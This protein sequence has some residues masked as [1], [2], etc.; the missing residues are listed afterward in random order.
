MSHWPTGMQQW[1]R[2]GIG[3]D[4]HGDSA[5]I[6]ASL[7]PEEIRARLCWLSNA[8]FTEKKYKSVHLYREIRFVKSKYDKQIK[9]PNGGISTTY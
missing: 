1:G 8:N 7:Y 3:W 5:G 4:C 2:G 6:E 9:I